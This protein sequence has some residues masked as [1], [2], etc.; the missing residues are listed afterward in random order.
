LVNSS[1]PDIGHVFSS[2]YVLAGGCL[3][4]HT[5]EPAHVSN[6]VQIEEPI[7]KR[8]SGHARMSEKRDTV[9]PGQSRTFVRNLQCYILS[10][11]LIISQVSRCAITFLL[12]CSSI[13]ELTY[14]LLVGGEYVCDK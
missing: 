2:F 13:S 7:K 6:L 1:V 12:R 3:S 9:V 5:W 4:A 14:R 8:D 10:G 11:K